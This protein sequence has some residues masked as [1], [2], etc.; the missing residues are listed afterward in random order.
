[1]DV[2]DAA[3][4]LEDF[5]T[6]AAGVGVGEAPADVLQ[7]LVGTPDEI[8][9]IVWDSATD[10]KTDYVRSVARVLRDLQ[11]EATFEEM[12]HWAVVA[13]VWPDQEKAITSLKPAWAGLI[14]I[15]PGFQKKRGK[16]IP[17]PLTTDAPAKVA[18]EAPEDAAQRLAAGQPLSEEAAKARL[19]MTPRENAE[20]MVAFSVPLRLLTPAG[21]ELLQSQFCAEAVA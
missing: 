17:P 4:D 9:A 1:M 13:G 14:K 5:Q 6:A 21:L 20:V 10:S 3:D 19:G 16:I 15:E 8:A 2:G 7:P 12:G 11:R 18:V